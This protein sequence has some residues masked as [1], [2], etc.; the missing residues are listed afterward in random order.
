MP[1]VTQ[2]PILST[3]TNQTYMLVVDNQATRRLSFAQVASQIGSIPIGPS[4][5]RGPSGPSGS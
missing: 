5:L 2:L 1:Q 4:G 3:A